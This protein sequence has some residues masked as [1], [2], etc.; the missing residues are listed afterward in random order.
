MTEKLL[1]L[2]EAYRVAKLA[3]IRNSNAIRETK[4]KLEALML[5]Q[6]PLALETKDARDALLQFA[7]GVEENESLKA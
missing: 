2:A 1:Q 3:V 5:E 6:E 4:V 7:L